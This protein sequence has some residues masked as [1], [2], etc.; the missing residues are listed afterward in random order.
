M[1]HPLKRYLACLIVPPTIG[2]LSL[3]AWELANSPSLENPPALIGRFPFYFA[4][5]FLFCLIP[6]TLFFFAH[7]A[8]TKTKSRPSKPRIFIV[9]PLLGAL[10]GFFIGIVIDVATLHN[11]VPIGIAAGAVTSWIILPKTPALSA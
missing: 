1:K 4:F 9:G 10:C 5:A 8:F 7:E 3:F 6:G 2:T 11:F